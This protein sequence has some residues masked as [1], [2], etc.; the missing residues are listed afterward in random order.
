MPK[1]P[2][3]LRMYLP[4]LFI[5]NALTL[6][7]CIITALLN[8]DAFSAGILLLSSLITS[9]LIFLPYFLLYIDRLSSTVQAIVI[10]IPFLISFSLL[11]YML[12]NLW[13]GH[14]AEMSFGGV[15]RIKF[16]QVRVIELLIVLATCCRGY[17]YYRV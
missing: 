11:V 7:L 8:R 14:W 2:I 16:W 3:F 4:A 1:K 13:T 10:F 5:C 12:Y 9:V 17:K 15:R 6:I